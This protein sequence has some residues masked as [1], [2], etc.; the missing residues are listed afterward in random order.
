MLP[1]SH[2][3]RKVREMD[4]ARSASDS[5]P[6]SVVGEMNGARGWCEFEFFVSHP[7]RKSAEWMGH[8]RD[9]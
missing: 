4:R 1:V 3:F 6:L 9:S 5:H 8:L 2:P 7:F